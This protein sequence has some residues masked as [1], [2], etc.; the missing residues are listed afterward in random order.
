MQDIYHLLE[1]LSSLDSNVLI[2]GESGTGKELVADALHYGGSRAGQPLIKVNCSALSESLLESELF[3]HVR[4]AFTGAV[5]DKVGRIQAAQG[6]TLFLDEIGDISPLI[7][8]KLLRFLEQK[9]YERVGESNTHTADVR[10]IAATNAKLLESVKQG[11]FREDLYYRLNVMPVTLPPLRERQADIPLLVEHFLGIFSNQFNKSFGR[12]SAEVMDL[13]MSYRWPGNIRELRHILEH[14]SILSS[15]GE[16]VLKYIRKDL[17][18]QMRASE[19]CE[20]EPVARY[21]PQL[22]VFHKVTREDILIA[23]DRCGGNK[24][25]AARQLGIHRATLYRKLKIQM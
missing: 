5:R 22:S 25:R 7:Q 15:G 21:V 18:D 12:V 20:S 14:A 8:L 11:I 3:G 24:A 19:F 13:F 16:I 2:L 4:G 1:Q 6:G 23:L 9:E 10:I 17:V